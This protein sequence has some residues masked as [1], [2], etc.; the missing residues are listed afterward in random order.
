M[1]TGFGEVFQSWSPAAAP[2]GGCVKGPESAGRGDAAVAQSAVLLHMAARSS[3]LYEDNVMSSG[4]T[5]PVLSGTCRGCIY[6][7]A[8]GIVV[9]RGVLDSALLSARRVRH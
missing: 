2:F 4:E 1:V 3:L 5:E 8:Y 7:K 9:R 6:K